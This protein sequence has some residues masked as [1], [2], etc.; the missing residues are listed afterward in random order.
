M[1]ASLN[2]VIE[3]ETDPEALNE[4]ALAMEAET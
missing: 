3:A 4:A 1:L 2:D